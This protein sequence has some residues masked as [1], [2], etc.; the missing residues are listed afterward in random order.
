MTIKLLTLKTGL[1]ATVALLVYAGIGSAH[2]FNN[3][4]LGAA[5]DSQD[6]Y[7]LR[8][9]TLPGGLPTSRL[10][11][12]VN[13]Q[14]GFGAGGSPILTNTVKLQIAKNGFL[15]SAV[16]ADGTNSAIYNLA[17]CNASSQSV[18]AV[19]NGGNDSYVIL[20]DKAGADTG[21]LYGAQ[22]HCLDVNGHLTGLAEELPSNT[23]LI[24][25]APGDIDLLIS[26]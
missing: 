21:R 15:P 25:P 19:L 24:S 10:V 2:C 8:C 7:H 13:M 20:I 3:A 17:T 5:R 16:V 9:Y 11:A 18:T 23:A 22:F 14:S 1:L 26:Q 12:N 4:I 6:L